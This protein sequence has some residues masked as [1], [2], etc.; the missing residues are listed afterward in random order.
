[1]YKRFRV[2]F[3]DTFGDSF[4]YSFIA[5]VEIADGYDEYYVI[6]KS[7]RDLVGEWRDCEEADESFMEYLY[8]NY[9]YVDGITDFYIERR[10]A[11]D[12]RIEF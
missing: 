8:E 1:M 11:V 2:K 4:D 7:L 5:V 12:F 10:P 3:E 6:N 9:R